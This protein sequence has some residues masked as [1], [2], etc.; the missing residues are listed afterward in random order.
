MGSDASDNGLIRI[1]QTALHRWREALERRVGANAAT[2]LQ[3]VGAASGADIYEAFQRWFPMHTG[4][5]DPG[6]LRADRFGEVLSAFFSEL[7]WGGLQVARLGTGGLELTSTDWAEAAPTANAAYP[8]C[9]LS[10]GML[11]DLLSR[12]ADA[13]IAI[14]EVECRSRRDP[15]CRFLAG[16]PETLEAA[17]DAMN[18]SRDYLA[19]FGV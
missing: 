10:A 14:M 9:Y 12:M 1:G 18:A 19:V 3:E 13:P 15:Q 6:E 5:D 4:L 2:C 8:T 17:Y 16:A 11:A 7:G